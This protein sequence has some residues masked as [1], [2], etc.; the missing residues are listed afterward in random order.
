MVL[1]PVG[2]LTVWTISYFPG[3]VS[4]ATVRE[5]SRQLA[6]AWA[7]RTL[8]ASTPAPMGRSETILPLSVLMT[9]SFCGFAAADEEAVGFG[10]DGH[11]DGRAAGGDGPA[12]DDISGLEVDDGYQVLVFEVDV[13]LSGA[14]GGE[15]LGLAAESDGVDFA[16]GGVDVGFEG[17]EGFAVA[18]DGEDAIRWRDRR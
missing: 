11:A 16:G 9:M 17:H 14:V 7:P 4:L 10:V 15:E 2:V 1:A 3:A 18:R 5:P 6:K 8:V 12:C 13:D